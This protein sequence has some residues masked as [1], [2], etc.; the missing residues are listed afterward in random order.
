MSSFEECRNDFAATR[1]GDNAGC[2]RM[3]DACASGDMLACNDLYYSARVMNSQIEL[4]GFFC[5]NRLTPEQQSNA[6]AG[7]CELM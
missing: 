5:G 2:D 7:F 1:P 3:H 6:V 4:F